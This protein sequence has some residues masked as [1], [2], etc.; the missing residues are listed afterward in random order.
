MHKSESF[1]SNGEELH[2]LLTTPTRY[3]D[4]EVTLSRGLPP[5]GN[6]F[7]VHVDSG[8]GWGT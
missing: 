8:R 4:V 7:R 1:H 3:L 2:L 5:N 6:L